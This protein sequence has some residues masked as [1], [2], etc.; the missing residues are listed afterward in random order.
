[1]LFGGGADVEVTS[2]GVVQALDLI[3]AQVGW[4]SAAPVMLNHRATAFQR[5]REHLE[6]VLEVFEVLRGHIALLSDDGHASAIRAPGFTEG[7]VN[8]KRQWLGWR[9]RSC[10]Q[11]LAVGVFIEAAGELD[12]RGIGRVSRART[13]VPLKTAGN[14]LRRSA[15][16]R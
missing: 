8:V 16:R 3:N 13:V 5:G 4:R 14:L 7:Q 9:L 15:G 1:R 12:G 11:P 2:N 6:F 10:T